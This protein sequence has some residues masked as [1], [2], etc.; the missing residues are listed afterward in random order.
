M[1]QVAYVFEESK[2]IPTHERELF[3][4]DAAGFFVDM[5]AVL[6]EHCSYTTPVSSRAAFQRAL[7]RLQAGD[8]L[9]T[10][11]LVSL[12][13]SVSEVVETLKMLAQ[14]DIAAVCL[15]YGKENLCSEDGRRFVRALE[16][17]DDLERVTRR[18]RARQAA[19]AARERGIVQGRP[20]SLSPA[21]QHQALMVLGAG[22]TV[23]EIARS[24]N[25]SRQTIMRLRDSHAMRKSGKIDG[26]VDAAAASAPAASFDSLPVDDSR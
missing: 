16:L 9:I 4:I 6:V 17:A 15:A 11:R 10:T 22:R 25:T 12:G 23:T 19:T 7:R 26:D 8:M 1:A 5:S 20:S 24:L 2:D 3:D 14:R 21:Q 18:S 13:N